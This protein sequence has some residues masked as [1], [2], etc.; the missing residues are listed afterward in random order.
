MLL[1]IIVLIL[2]LLLLSVVI[3]FFCVA[4]LRWNIGNF[5]DVNDPCNR[6][7]GEF[8]DAVGKGIEHIN[9]TPC[10]WVETKSFD[11]LKIKARYF[12]NGQ[13]NTLIFFHGY[14]SSASRDF[15]CALK[16]YTDLGLNIL[17]VDQRS[18]GKSEGKLITFGVKESRDVVSWVKFLN[19]EYSPEGI[20]LSGMSMG[21]TTV[22]LA[23]GG[24]LPENVKG[25]IADCG[26]TSPTEIIKSVALRFLKIK[27]QYLLPLINLCC[28]AFGGFSIRKASTVESLKKCLLPVL[29]IHGEADTFVPCEMSR[30][31]FKSC[32]N[33]SRLVTVENA[34]HGMSFLV[35]GEKV[36]REIKDFL[37]KYVN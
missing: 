30:I 10:K 3:Y 6:V 32:N 31:A 15:S 12:D 17:L 24:F 1:L 13:K 7:L 34:Y 16:F 35:D 19:K 9:S 36:K 37:A 20:V 26:Y 8:K 29:L 27:A 5:D 4:C 28:K 14:R 25:I 18:H 22:L 21:A 33:K 11:G 23:A 2:L